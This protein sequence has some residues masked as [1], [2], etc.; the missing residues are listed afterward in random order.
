MAEAKQSGW[1]VI[2]TKDDWKFVAEDILQ[3]LCPECG[4]QGHYPTKHVQRYPRKE[5]EQ[6]EGR[7][8]A[9]RS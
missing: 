7:T 6:S 9:N 1:T 5:Q 3:I 2:S 8:L 4:H